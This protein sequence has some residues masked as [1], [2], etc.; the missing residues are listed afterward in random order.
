MTDK[1]NNNHNIEFDAS[2][3][4]DALKNIV[5]DCNKII[6]GQAERIKELEDE[7][8]IAKQKRM[9]L[10]QTI[11]AVERG[12]KIGVERFVDRLLKESPCYFRG[13]ARKHL[14]ELVDRIMR[15]GVL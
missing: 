8:E 10:F 13:D 14:F 6:N 7:L 2:R 5:E 4:I 12:K 1:T 9:N 11:N 15:G 3:H